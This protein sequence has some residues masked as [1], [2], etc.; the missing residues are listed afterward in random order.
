MVSF[1]DKDGNLIPEQGDQRS[2]TPAPVLIRKDSM[3]KNPN[4]PF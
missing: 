4:V 3:L 1:V 2:I